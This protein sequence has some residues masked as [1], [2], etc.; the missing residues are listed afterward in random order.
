MVAMLDYV[1]KH[2]YSRYFGTRMTYDSMH[3]YLTHVRKLLHRQIHL[4]HLA[5]TENNENKKNKKTSFCSKLHQ[6]SPDGYELHCFLNL[7]AMLANLFGE[8]YNCIVVQ[9]IMADLSYYSNL[10]TDVM[11]FQ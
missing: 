3:K 4:P 1:A 8:L 10:I 2:R 6:G 7:L 5:K 9:T 11:K